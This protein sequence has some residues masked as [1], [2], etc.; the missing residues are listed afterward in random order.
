MKV[1]ASGHR[2]TYDIFVSYAHADLR[3]PFVRGFRDHLSAELAILSGREVRIFQT[4]GG[5]GDARTT[6][7]RP[8]STDDVERIDS[9]IDAV[10]ASAVIVFLLSRRFLNRPWF[11]IELTEFMAAH[12]ND[13]TPLR[14]RMFA[15]LLADFDRRELPAAMA[16]EVTRI[17]FD[18]D[19]IPMLFRS[20][21]QKFP[22]M[23]AMHK[24]ALAIAETIASHTG[25]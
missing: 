1:N 25:M 12:R 15:V 23:A 8:K 24:L 7:T 3:H 2:Y 20:T 16:E 21:M 4:K 22:Y 14:S 13:G 17:D 10:H 9:I 18:R 19:R 6:S 11:D 5:S